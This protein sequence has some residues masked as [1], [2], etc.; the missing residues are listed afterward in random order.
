MSFLLLSINNFKT[1]FFG[2]R[3][4]LFFRL[5]SFLFILLPFTLVTG[6]FLPDL[7]LSLIA[8]YFLIISLINKLF[9]YYRN[10]AVYFF[11]AFYSCILISGLIS[12]N[13]YKSLIDYNGPIFFFRYLFFVLGICYLLDTNSNLIRFFCFNLMI[14]LIFTIFDGFIMWGFGT[15]ILGFQQPSA[16]VTGIFNE[17]EILGHFLSHIV[18]LAFSLLVYIFGVRPKYIA[19]SWTFD[20]IYVMILNLLLRYERDKYRNNF[21]FVSLLWSVH[22]SEFQY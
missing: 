2:T 10:I 14:V 6:P 11:I 17:E 18:P 20:N 19:L 13:P 5:I 15:N 9:N 1:D 16:R 12:D 21:A 4:S 8:L 7:F 3:F 22:T